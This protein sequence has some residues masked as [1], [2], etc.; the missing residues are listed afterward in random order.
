MS[1]YLIAGAACGAI[2]YV[3]VAILITIIAYASSPHSAPRGLRFAISLGIGLLWVI[4]AFAGMVAFSVA[5]GV[6]IVVLLC[7]GG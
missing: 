4:L 1:A 6:Y 3:A 5:G 2:A 7:G